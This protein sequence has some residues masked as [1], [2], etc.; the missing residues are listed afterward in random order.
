MMVSG[1]VRS[2]R[3]ADMNDRGNMTIEA[4]ILMPLILA[5]S[6]I[7]I[8]LPIRMYQEMAV[9]NS[10]YEG[11]LAYGRPDSDS[12]REATV[13]GRKSVFY[14]QTKDGLTTARCESG[15]RTYELTLNCPEEGVIIWNLK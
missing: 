3:E 7:L 11:A 15:G 2:A 4:A 6:L 1:P 5:L 12:C 14:F 13:A 10:L 8:L 9:I